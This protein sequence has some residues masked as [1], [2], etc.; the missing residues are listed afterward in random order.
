MR[1]VIDQ[2]SSFHASNN[3]IITLDKIGRIVWSAAL[4]ETLLQQGVIAAS[5]QQHYIVIW[6][7]K[8]KQN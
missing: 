8:V 5:C 3:Q 6:F 4:K 1:K 7:Y 2:T